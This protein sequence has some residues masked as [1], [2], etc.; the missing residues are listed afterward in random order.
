M[1]AQQW[2]HVS[3]GKHRAIYSVPRRG[4]ESPA[5]PDKGEASAASQSAELFSCHM[6]QKS[7]SRN[8]D[9][10]LIAREGDTTTL[11]LKGRQT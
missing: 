9:F 4:G 5:K 6:T 11:G 2:S 10:I 1:G 7:K 3:A 8:A